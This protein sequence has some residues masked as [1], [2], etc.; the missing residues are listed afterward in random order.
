MKTAS[1][2]FLIFILIILSGCEKEQHYLATVETSPVTNITSN[3]A[4]SGGVITD[5]GSTVALACGVAW[6]TKP[7]PWV[8]DFLT[9]D[10]LGTDTFV[11]K[12]LN[13]EPATTYYVRAYAINSE[14][15]S[16]GQQLSFT[17]L[18][19]FAPDIFTVD[20]SSVSDNS[21]VSGGYLQNPSNVKIISRGVCWDTLPAPETSDFLSQPA[22]EDTLYSCELRN[23][24]PGTTYYYRAFV[25]FD[26]GTLYGEEKEFTTL[27]PGA[28]VVVT[29]DA[30]SVSYFSAAAGGTIVNTEQA[31]IISKG[32]CWDTL[33]V[34]ETSDFLSQ[35]A[36]EDTIYSCELRNLLPGKTYYYRAFVIFDGGT[37][38]GEEKEFTTLIPGAPIVVTN[39]ATSVSYFSATAGGTIEKTGQATIISKGVCWDTLP[40][41]ET[42]DLLSQAATEDTIY[43][44][45]LRNLLPGKTYY[46]RAFV[47][48]DGGTVYGD[49]KEF[50]TP[51]IPLPEV[52]TFEVTGVNATKAVCHGHIEA[53]S[54]VIIVSEG[55]CYSESAAPDLNDLSTSEGWEAGDFSSTISDLDPGTT[56]YVRAYATTCDGIIYGNEVFFT[57]HDTLPEVT[58]S[59]ITSVTHESAVVAGLV[60]S[61]GGAPVTSRGLCWSESTEP[62]LSDQY[63][64]SG[65]GTGLFLG[66]ISGLEIKTTYYVR[67]FATNKNGTVYGEQL[68]FTTQDTAQWILV[69]SDDFE[70]YVTGDHPSKWT[71]RFDGNDAEVSEDVAYEGT[72]SFMLSSKS[73]WARVEAFPLDSVPDELKFEGAV[74]VNQA[75]KGYFIGFGF[76]ESA[77]TYRFR[78]GTGLNNSNVFEFIGQDTISWTP[79]TWYKIEVQMNMVEDRARLWI[80]DQFIAE[81]NGQLADKTDMVDFAIGG[82]NFSGS[83]ASKAYYDDIKLYFK[84]P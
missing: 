26:G 69:F 77:N 40:A 66:K 65:S 72:K 44:C 32:V 21:A 43:S 78:N 62:S 84:K 30:T 22:S 68:H 46:Y 2:F 50:I 49:Q 80:D 82:Y 54:V 67:A 11:S 15:T 20:A 1:G 25:I 12:L 7:M 3:S 75:F 8:K 55:F 48:F 18:P 70:D 52:E 61:D 38:Y 5:Y 41:P 83:T 47:I 4:V 24:L 14:G 74:Y 16:Y 42:S 28:P 29:N 71:T 33:P 73:S 45:G 63:L 81:V 53:D 37:V 19:E 23:L 9:N 64:Q 6:N 36:T 51:T 13:L 59:E 76:K 60:I 31:T 57:T 34:P 27:I 17:T 10:S 56:Y 39:D 58:T 35:A 79:Q